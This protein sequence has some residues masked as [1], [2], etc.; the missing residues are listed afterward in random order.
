MKKYLF[1]ILALTLVACDSDDSKSNS[2]EKKASSP[3]K[4]SERMGSFKIVM[5]DN[6]YQGEIKC[7]IQKTYGRAVFGNS[8]DPNRT[9]HIHGNIMP[10]K[11]FILYV[12][13]GDVSYEGYSKD[14]NVDEE[15]ATGSLLLMKG[16]TRDE[17]STTFVFTCNE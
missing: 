17:T 14:Y 16:G 2:N 12:K 3:N 4:V 7:K 8:D 11:E 5:G 10:D 6:T 9:T 15:G 13:D 1:I